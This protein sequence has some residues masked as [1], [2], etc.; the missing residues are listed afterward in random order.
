MKVEIVEFNDRKFVVK[1]VVPE[2]HISDE[3]SDIIKTLQGCDVVLRKNGR[4]FYC[5]EIEEATYEMFEM[6]KRIS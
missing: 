4:M 6:R 5:E 2:A 1:R 3:M